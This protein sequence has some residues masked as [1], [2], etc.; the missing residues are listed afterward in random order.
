MLP[1]QQ[2][3]N[4]HGTK[5]ELLT[6]QDEDTSQTEKRGHGVSVDNK[7]ESCKNFNTNGD[8][9]ANSQLYNYKPEFLVIQSEK[10]NIKQSFC[11]DVEKRGEIT[12]KM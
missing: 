6:I 1:G 8:A 7:K 4:L 11:W 2:K 9:N 10:D 12:L 3:E 5:L